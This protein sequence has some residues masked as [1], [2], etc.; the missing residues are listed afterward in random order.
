[1]GFFDTWKVSGI[2]TDASKASE[3]FYV[4]AQE[5]DSDGQYSIPKEHLI[6]SA[7]YFIKLQKNFELFF[8]RN[9]EEH[10]TDAIKF[11]VAF[12]AYAHG[13]DYSGWEWQSVRHLSQGL[14]T[15]MKETPSEFDLYNMPLITNAKT[16]VLNF[17]ASNS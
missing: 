1:M 9:Q 13:K 8:I 6:H 16:S 4:L 2:T 12:A 15:S 3:P 7:S 14:Y 10:K 5:M 17:I 11:L